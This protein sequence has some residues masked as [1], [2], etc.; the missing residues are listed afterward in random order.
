MRL[1]EQSID[2]AADRPERRFPN[3]RVIHYRTLGCFAEFVSVPER[4]KPALG[5][6]IDKSPR[7][8]KLD[9]LDGHPLPH[10]EMSTF[11]RDGLPK[12]YLAVR[13]SCDRPFIRDVHRLSVQ[14][15][16]THQVKANVGRSVDVS[17]EDDRC[18]SDQ[19]GRADG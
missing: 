3:Q 2:D 10:A 8:V 4:P 7:P 6:L 18:H 11:E 1:D 5:H 17:F 16:V 12:P 9:D 15:D 14:A 19:L 13:H